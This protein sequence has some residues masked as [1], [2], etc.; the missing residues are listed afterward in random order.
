MN[1]TPLNLLGLLLATL[2]VLGGCAT[3]TATGEAERLAQAGQNEQALEVLEKAAALDPGNLKIRAAVIR[4]RELVVARLAGQIDGQ[5]ASGRLDAA[6][7]MLARLEA[8]DAE[9]PRVQSARTAIERSTR[10]ELLLAQARDAVAKGR[11]DEARP[12]LR[13]LL[14]EAPGHPAAR[15]EMLRLRE[16]GKTID[17]PSAMGAA[18]QRPVTIEFR[19]A[20]LRAVLEG[21]S[22]T[23]GVNFVFDK[24]VRTD[25]KL[26]I[27]LKDVTVDEALRVILTTQQLDR[28]ILNDST[29]LIY[30]NTLAKQRE[31][32][33]LIARSFY[34]TN[35]DVKQAQTLVRTMVKTRDLFVDE[36]LNLIVVRDTPDVLAI[37]EKLLA[38][39]DLAEPE[40]ML[41][42]EILEIA[43]SKLDELGL[44]WPEQV[45]FGLPG[46]ATQISSSDNG[47]LRG[48][49]A[50]PAL[51]ATLRG[52]LTRGNLLANPRL[53][54]RN[55]E[56]AKIMIGEKLPVFA[57]T[58][59]T[60]NVAGT[61]TVTSLDVGL[62]LEIEP[63][64]QLDNDVIMKVNLELSRLIA[65][66][67]GPAGSIG[68]Q[69]GNRQANTSL[70]LRDGETQVLAGLISDEESK[71]INGIPGLAE[72]PFAGRLF[73]VQ[74]DGR[75]K[76]ELVLLI[77]PRVIR[78]IGLPDAAALSVP[79]GL[80]A[81]PGAE[82]LRLKN[83]AK[84]SLAPATGRVAGGAAG[85]AAAARAQQ[86]QADAA[87]A[88]LL[89]ST[90]G[91]VEAGGTAAVTL[92]NRS[93][94]YM[95]GDIEFDPE[96]F[97]PV[98]GAAAGVNRVPFEI[99]GGGQ[100]VVLLRVLP[101]AA[102]K[103]SGVSVSNLVVEGPDGG[104]PPFEV[105]G[106]GSLS[107]VAP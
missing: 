68:Y 63:S 59:A 103:S 90:S 6:R 62:K 104:T 44:K 7:A 83:R 85:G 88:A 26:S 32:Q 96:L 3:S 81:S 1:P 49:I 36:R 58:A 24:D 77:T 16:R 19:D 102:G 93:S 29:L 79:S 92:Q 50:N 25:T 91:Q 48:L 13:Q 86:D 106:D 5:L 39:L 99:A 45:S 55:R 23:H 54:A 8:I 65:K 98:Q 18:F 33:E 78:N 95:K 101:A 105:T 61:T 41:E 100:Q 94:A 74:T 35:A 27:M 66:V 43:S 9:N 20:P 107:V 97:Q 14:A 2:L 51:V 40:V 73:G 64:V 30:P 72:L 52:T 82:S 46:N 31:N 84:V 56:K 69:V 34:L 67:A 4:Q 76:T 15:V 89:L 12:L 70:R 21:L 11:D 75:T 10:H 87:V 22:R 53:R 47:D 60:A 38:G 28:R 57:S 37:V 42:V 17:V 71:G 80:E